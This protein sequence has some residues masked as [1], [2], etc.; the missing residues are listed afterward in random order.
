MYMTYNSSI[1]CVARNHHQQHTDVPIDKILTYV[2]Y[3]YIHILISSVPMPNWF[4][5]MSVK[6]PIYV[7]ILPKGLPIWLSRFVYQ[8]LRKERVVQIT[9]TQYVFFWNLPQKWSIH[10]S[11][12]CECKLKWLANNENIQMYIL[13]SRD[14]QV[15]IL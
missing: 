9:C 13:L 11:L 3:Y 5:V 12:Y 1:V 2:V 8:W 14:S 7:H 6:K 15:A 10:K 4:I